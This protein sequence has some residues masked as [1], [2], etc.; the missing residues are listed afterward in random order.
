M[1][2]VVIVSA[3]RT[4]LGK[5][6]G[7]LASFSAPKLGSLVVREAINRAGI[8]PEMVDEVIMGCV[9]TAG[10]GQNPARQAAIW[11]GVPTKSAALT[12]NKVCGSGL[13]AVMLASSEIK[14]G[15]VRIVVAGGMESMTNAPYLLPEARFG[16]RLGH[17]KLVDAMVYD[18]LW[19]IYNNFHMGLTAELVSEKY[20][21]SRQDQDMFA[22]NSHQKAVRAIK[23][24]KFK[25][26]ILPI[27]IPQPKGK[28]PF[29]F[30]KDE[31]P[32][33]DTTLEKLAKLN[34]A[35][36]DKGTVT[37]GNAS[38][39][40]DGAAATVV[41]SEDMAKE[42]KLKPLGRII[43]Y[44]TGGVAPEWVMM[45]PLEAVKNLLFKTG[46]KITDFDLIEMN[47][48]FSAQGV[49]LTKELKLDSQRVNVNGG[50]VA[51][52]HPIGCSG[53]RVLTTLIYALKDRKLK[54]GLATL[55]LGGGNAVAL[56]IE[57]L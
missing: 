33:A 3:V 44:A 4:A 47:E 53:T 7:G 54:R 42:L 15:D 17:G 49:A 51:L 22:F 28:P 39:I 37:A 26:E 5:F 43:G 55:C 13:K 41:M 34:P 40:S 20:N 29:I 50:A 31:G 27:E 32:R 16:Q 48:A 14:A 11:G 6:Q 30:D 25:Q 2:N 19:D 57:I 23:E 21:V 18:G 1:T 10:L 35:F 36:K 8:S 9:V 45:A 38:Q 24:G 56:A 52:G 46:L 12:V